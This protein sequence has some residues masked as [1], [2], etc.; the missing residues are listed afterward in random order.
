MVV[1][2]TL[3]L[4]YHAVRALRRAYG[5]KI[6]EA[7]PAA[8]VPDLR[9]ENVGAEQLPEDD[10]LRL[11]RDLASKGEFR[12]ALR[13]LYL[14][15]LAHL[16]RR[17]LIVLARFKSNREY[18]RELARRARAVPQ[19]K[20]LFAENVSAFDRVWYGRHQATAELLAAVE[21]NVAQLRAS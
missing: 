11:A 8:I 4:V 15:S 7:V 5:E 12:L 1:V 21:A 10:W 9:D 20:T 16:A 14:A 19:L 18:E 6:V 17:E 2:A 13:A 3:L